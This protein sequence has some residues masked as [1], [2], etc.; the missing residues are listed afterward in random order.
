M[1]D[2]YPLP[3][4]PP[5]PGNGTGLTGEYFSDVNFTSLVKTQ[6][7]G[8]LYNF[9][10]GNG[11]PTNIDRTPMSGM[12]SHNFS[13][14]WTGQIQAMEEGNY[15]IGVNADDTAKIWIGDLN[16]APLINKTAAGGTG[17]TTKA[18]FKMAAGQKYNIKIEFTDISGPADIQ[19]HWTRP[20]LMGDIVRRTQLY[21]A[22]QR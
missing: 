17:S 21:P 8:Q 12:P 19:L 13:V 9:Q 20:G 10:W 11:S 14:R 3:T 5:T 18:S 7:D 15:T 2:V 6:I 4:V 16:G 1:P 22:L